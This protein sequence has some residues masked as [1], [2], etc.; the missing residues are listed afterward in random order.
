MKTKQ[1]LALSGLAMT[2]APL[3]MQLG[4]IAMP[5]GFQ[6]HKDAKGAVYLGGSPNSEIT[7]TIGGVEASRN[8][9]ASACGTA[10]IK[11]S[12]T[13]PVPSMFKIGTNIINVA[14]LPTQLLPK[15]LATGQLEEART[16]NFKTSAG[17][18]VIV[19]QSPSASIA[20]TF[21]E[22]KAKKVKINACGWGR[23]SNSSTKPFTS[24]ATFDS[25]AYNDI[26][27]QTVWLCRDGITY[28]PVSGGS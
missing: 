26:P 16:A 21:N 14:N 25:T 8:L 10:V 7:V 1:F 23:I 9:T 3:V 18:V 27:T 4:A 6:T 19:G 11:N 28:K 22:E 20:M 17:D 5:A 2:A 15:C 12:T 24:T 13:R